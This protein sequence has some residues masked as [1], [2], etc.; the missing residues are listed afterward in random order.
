M[1]EVLILELALKINLLKQMGLLN[2]EGIPKL[3]PV[4]YLNKV[5]SNLLV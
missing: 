1:E 5:S 3:A 2:K 4:R